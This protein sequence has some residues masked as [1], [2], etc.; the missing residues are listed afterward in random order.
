MD[1]SCQIQILFDKIGDV[2]EDFLR[3]MTMK[4]IG[5]SLI[6]A[7]QFVTL[8]NGGET[9][10]LDIRFPFETRLWGMSFA[11]AIPLNELPDRLAELPRDK[12]IVC[13]CPLD[14]RSNIACQFLLQQG[15]TAKIL[16]GGLLALADR[17]RGG[18]ANDLK[19]D[20]A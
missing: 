4:D 18:A 13:A 5:T 14:I 10:L 19:L 12:T 2:M 16:V 20:R 1:F 3:S 8:F 6:S 15:F 9:V 11:V 7:D 17:L